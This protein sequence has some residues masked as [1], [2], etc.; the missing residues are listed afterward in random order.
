MKLGATLF[1]IGLLGTSSLAVA[2]EMKMDMPKGQPKSQADMAFEQAM[3]KMSSDMNVETTGKPDEDFVRM[4][5]PHHQGAI[6][7]AKVELRYG[8]DPTLRRMAQDIVSSQEKEIREMRD[9]QDK[10]GK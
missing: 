10:H 4:M 7:M 3:S 5:T 9:W 6:D 2:E 1:A 8:T